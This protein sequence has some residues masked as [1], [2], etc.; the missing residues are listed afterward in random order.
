MS[1]QSQ[2]TSPSVPDLLLQLMRQQE[3]GFAENRK[4]LQDFGS[5]INRIDRVALVQQTMDSLKGLPQ[6]VTQLEIAREVHQRSLDDYERRITAN[7]GHLSTVMTDNNQRKGLEG[8]VGKVVVGLITAL[9]VALLGAVL[10]VI[11]LRAG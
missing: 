7:S 2:S 8:P 5:T 4:A 1:D 11:G 9:G 10:W 6:R 3:G